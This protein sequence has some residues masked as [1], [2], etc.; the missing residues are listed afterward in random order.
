MSVCMSA[1]SG[2]GELEGES[3]W[4]HRQHSKKGSLMNKYKIPIIFH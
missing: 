4:R 2:V 1:C 3:S